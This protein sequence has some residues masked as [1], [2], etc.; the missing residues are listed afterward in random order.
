VHGA[1]GSRHVPSFTRAAPVQCELQ[2]LICLPSLAVDGR[3]LH[4]CHRPN[5]PQT[6]SCP[7]RET[8]RWARQRPFSVLCLSRNEAPALAAV[9]ACAHPAWVRKLV[10][11]LCCVCALLP[12]GRRSLRTLA[13]RAGLSRRC[14]VRGAARLR[15]P[16]RVADPFHDCGPEQQATAKPGHRHSPNTALAGSPAGAAEL[17]CH[18]VGRQ[19]PGSPA[20]KPS[21]RDARTPEH[22]VCSHRRPPVPILAKP[23][24]SQRIEDH[25]QKP[26]WGLPGAKAG[27]AVPGKV[28]WCD[29]LG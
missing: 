3:V 21:R 28:C 2:Y 16:L 17:P 27:G 15:T 23:A 14:S 24:P 18:P 29:E 19:P 13:W 25:A 26:A 1:W 10:L 8:P 4:P 9:R 12:P 22:S 7:L 11:R 20:G 5:S 6:C